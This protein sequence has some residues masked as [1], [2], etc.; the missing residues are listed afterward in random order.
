MN[1]PGAPY[2]TD[3]LYVSFI[4]LLILTPL[5]NLA[6]YDGRCLNLEEFYCYAVIILHL[7]LLGVISISSGNH[8][9]FN[10]GRTDILVL[11]LFVFVFFQYVRT[12]IFSYTNHLFL[13]LVFFLVLY[14]ILKIGDLKHSPL[15]ISIQYAFAC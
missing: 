7:F 8:V 1:K 14:L 2:I 3:K 13:R 10:I 15:M 11:I 6:D 5:I 4:V 9:Q 12:D